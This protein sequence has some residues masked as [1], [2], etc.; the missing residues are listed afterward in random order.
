[1]FSIRDSVFETNS[2]STHAISFLK[3]I[4]NDTVPNFIRF[5]LGEYGWNDGWVDPASYLYTA[6]VCTSDTPDIARERIDTLKKILDKNNIKYTFED[7]RWKSYSAE[8]YYVR[9][10]GIDHEDECSEFV[11][12][13]LTDEDALIRYLTS[14]RV[15]CTND[16][17]DH[18]IDDPL[19]Y[20]YKEIYTYDD[21]LVKNPYFD[22]KYEYYYKGN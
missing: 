8:E 9:Y 16:N 5:Y 20:G 12:R 11:H 14:G 13:M 15:Y 19:N 18:E 6:I 17:I 1:M 3:D 22:D 21:K 4:K 7:I 10:A 2:S